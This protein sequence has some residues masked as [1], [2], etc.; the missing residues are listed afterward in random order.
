[1]ASS[2]EYLDFILEKLSE[3]DDISYRAMMGEYIIYYRGKIVGGIYDDRFLVKNVKATSELMPD[4]SL[5][6]PYEGAK[7]MLL[8][9]DIDNKLLLKD[10]LEAMYDEL[11]EPKK[12]K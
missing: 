11:P 10:L 12:K 1:M 3:L 2:K 5:E 8:V 9:D 6:L 4:A 7:E